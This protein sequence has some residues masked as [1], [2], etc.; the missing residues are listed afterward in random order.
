MAAISG[1]NKN[2]KMGPT[3]GVATE[4][5]LPRA[6]RQMFADML[7]SDRRTYVAGAV[8][9]NAVTAI[10]AW[11]SGNILD[12]ILLLALVLTSL[13][14]Y[15]QFSEYARLRHTL[16]TPEASQAWENKY[17]SQAAFFMLLIGLLCFLSFAYSKDVFSQLLSGTMAIAM[18]MGVIG[19]NF[20]SPSIVRAQ[21][22]CL[23]APYI[24]GLLIT[25]E[26]QNLLM[27]C[28]ILPFMIAVRRTTTTLRQLFFNAIY[29]S[30]EASV[31]AN[32]FDAA[33]TNL[34]HGMSMFDE[35]GRL[36]VSNS[37]W[38]H[39]LGLDPAKSRFGWTLANV[40]DE[41]IR[42]GI[43]PA[44][45]REMLIEALGPPPAGH[46]TGRRNDIVIGGRIFEL[47]SERLANGGFL[48]LLDD[49]T[50][51]AEAQAR[52]AHITRY[53]ILTGLPN[54][55][56]FQEHVETVL[57]GQRKDDPFAIL[58]VDVDN[59]K[60]VNDTL[61]HAVGDAL[62]FEVAH[63]I[64]AQLRA[65]DIVA[66]FSGDEFVILQ[67]HCALENDAAS[68]A[69]RIID[70]LA[71][72]CAIDGQEV[73]ISAS[74]GIALAPRDGVTIDM[75]F[76]KAD[77]A[78]S[79]AKAGGRKIYEFFQDAMDERAQTRRALELDMRVAIK[80][81]LFTVF[82]QP[83]YNIR[84]NTVSVCEA[85]ARW[86]HPEKGMIPPGVFIPLAEENGMIVEI[87]TQILH[88]A[89]SECAQW[90]SNVNVAV[91]L[92]PVQLRR[93]DV[94]EMIA[95]T[96]K[97]TGLAPHR[98]EIEITESALLHDMDATVEVL[99]RL[100]RMGVRTALDDFGTGYSSLS[101]L[102][103]LPLNKV[104]IDRSF[105]RDIETDSRAQ[106]LL[107]SVTQL[108]ADLGMTVVIEGVETFDQL[109]ILS[110]NGSVDEVQGYLFSPPSPA[111]VVRALLKEPDYGF[112]K[113]PE[114][115]LRRVVG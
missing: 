43:I 59:F 68:L 100:R 81:D 18:C 3:E 24:T 70:A 64:G 62:L 94:V 98:L 4:S 107:R 114:H 31:L 113:M 9:C 73:I 93:S 16:T 11:R 38:S 67:R 95:R 71:E 21:L 91:N 17:E 112:D 56:F 90:P 111:H 47:S 83:L 104:K 115:R 106:K 50:A 44:D 28:F 74:V 13:Y 45:Q 54:R 14:R 27:A 85:L 78:L 89:C 8:S 105:L 36:V 87:G 20:T 7:F 58:F 63:R 22:L 37:R 79:R 75:L 109:A 61:G 26:L 35:H 34:P 77:M 84:R 76:K 10:V 15:G 39:F 103:N 86:P 23:F 29:A 6:S 30:H 108:S 41:Q 60:D 99:H 110:A 42:E 101:H 33:L 40:I 51:K 53:D 49:V 65:L 12:W 69:T 80:Q 32:R 46:L 48:T 82:F 72:P 52:L 19:R 5:D 92:S 96:L 2:M 1:D 88:K 55:A 57:R 66:R 97:E 102:Q 25:G